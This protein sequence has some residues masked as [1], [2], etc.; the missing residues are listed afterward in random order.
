VPRE[1]RMPHK[2]HI[3]DTLNFC[4]SLA[5]IPLLTLSMRFNVCTLVLIMNIAVISAHL[6]LNNDQ[7]I[8][9]SNELLRCPKIEEIIWTIKTSITA[10][11]LQLV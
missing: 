7:S 6:M 9:Q 3:S 8:N 10:L 5:H 1:W 11:F 4:P 2:M